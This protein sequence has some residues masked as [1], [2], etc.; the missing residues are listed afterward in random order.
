MKE[1]PYLLGLFI[2]LLLLSF[3]N[4]LSFLPFTLIA[5]FITYRIRRIYLIVSI[6]ISFI[7]ITD[8]IVGNN[9]I[10]VTTILTL[11]LSLI[12]LKEY[13]LKLTKYPRLPNEISLII[14]IL[15]ISFLIS[16]FHSGSSDS[17]SAILR[18]FIFL[19]ICYMIYSFVEDEKTVILY[20]LALIIAG[21]I[22]S[23]SIYY[24]FI[25]GG[26]NFFLATG[27]LVRFAGIYGN[28]NFIGLLFVIITIL[29]VALFF[30][31][32]F[33]KR[34]RKL[35]LY[36]ITFN[37][38]FIILVT[39][40][41]AA[42]IALVLGISFVLF[43]LN[44]KFF[45]KSFIISSFI[46][47]I[48]FQVPVIDDFLFVIIRPQDT[49]SREHLWDSGRE[50]FSQNFFWGVGPDEFP[51]HFYTF[52]PSSALNK[53]IEA[54]ALDFGK[55]PSPHNFFIFMAA[56]N[57]ILGLVS[58]ILLLLI[59]FFLAIKTMIRSKY[60]NNDIYILSVSIIGIGI[61]V[62]FRSFFEVG[63]LLSYGYISRDLPFWLV[64]IILIYLYR[65]TMGRQKEVRPYNQL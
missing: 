62:V 23:I 28:P 20:I 47:L 46:L 7:V 65:I 43:M 31:K 18:F 40:S 11:I 10:I 41:R 42:I 4:Y 27:F 1:K 37:N 49:S 36:F 50:M 3:Q 60:S 56:E 14:S 38:L 33:Q 19:I 13:G 21:Y 22:T 15:F 17:L 51:N 5:L 35:F 34:T 55:R 59:F 45:I 30:S 26:F 16:A 32:R 48:L 61:A 39:D 57:G 53:F 9:R 29:T 44:R 12:F 52:F 63:G 6:I 24:D 25:K 54:G 58:S 2:T 8:V 64:F